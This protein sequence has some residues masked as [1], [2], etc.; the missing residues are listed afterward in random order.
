MDQPV[1]GELLQGGE[2]RDCIHVAIAPVVCKDLILM[3]GEHIGIVANHPY[4]ATA[5]DCAVYI[6][7]VDP[8]L[9]SPVKK[10][11]CFY[12]FLYPNTVTGLRHMWSHPAFVTKIPVVEG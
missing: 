2:R 6:G 1:L 11:E 12:L 10:G 5:K 9:K 3:P 8:F 4:F 7:I